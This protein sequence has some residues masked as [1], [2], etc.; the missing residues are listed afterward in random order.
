MSFKNAKFWLLEFHKVP[1]ALVQGLVSL[2][3][4]GWN[5]MQLMKMVV[6]SENK[7]WLDIS[8]FSL[9]NYGL[10]IQLTV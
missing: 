4:S 3:W 6:T 2:L 10:Q 7:C 8:H 9:T 5:V 1:L